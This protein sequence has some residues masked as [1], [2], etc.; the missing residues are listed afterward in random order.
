MVTSGIAATHSACIARH[1]SRMLA[2]TEFVYFSAHPPR[3]KATS[4]ITGQSSSTRGN[5]R[6]APEATVGEYLAS[7]LMLNHIAILMITQRNCRVLSAARKIGDCFFPLRT[8]HPSSS[9]ESDQFRIENKWVRE[10]SCD[11]LTSFSPE[12]E[13]YY[14]TFCCSR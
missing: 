3:G 5:K 14:E 8:R 2:V 13:L 9:Q 11:R 4:N 12:R 10:R 7:S 6:T 1:Y